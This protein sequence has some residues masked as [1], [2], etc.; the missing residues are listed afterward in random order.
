MWKVCRSPTL[1]RYLQTITV[2]FVNNRNRVRGAV[3]SLSQ[4]G[5]WHFFWKFQR[6]ELKGDQSN[7][8]KFNPPLFSLFNTFKNFR[9]RGRG[10]GGGVA[11]SIISYFLLNGTVPARLISLRVIKVFLI[12]FARWRKAQDPEPAL[13]LWLTDPDTGGPKTY[14]SYGSESGTL[15]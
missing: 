14:G 10:G 6:E 2:L 13:Y 12:I 11:V 8:T 15:H 3:L 7:D 1:C 5:A 4:D 9:G